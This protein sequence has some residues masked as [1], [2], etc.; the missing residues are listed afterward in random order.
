M[1]TVVEKSVYTC[2]VTVNP[3]EQPVKPEN[4]AKRHDEIMQAAYEVLAEKGYGGTSMLAVAKRAAASNET[5]YKWYGNKQGL[6]RAMV[7]NNAREAAILLRD[8]LENGRNP[9]DTVARAGSALLRL[10]TGDKAIALNRAAA[11]DATDTG[12]LGGTIV[13]SGRETIVPL[14]TQLFEQARVAGL[15]SF[16][17]AATVTEI[18]VGLL[19]GDL[20]I[21][22]VIGV[23]PTLKAKEIQQRADWAQRVIMK[24]FEP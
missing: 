12:I 24:L 21:R 16:N 18:Y 10:V 4:R 3:G 17:D 23:Q 22:R 20:Q 2:T 8:S 11:A 15:M 5:L 9:S 7:E 13:R 19:I 14:L 1:C 6:F